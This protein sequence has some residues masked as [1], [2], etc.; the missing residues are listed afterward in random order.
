MIKGKA[1]TY[2]SGCDMIKAQSVGQ[3]A[4]DYLIRK[5]CEICLHEPVLELKI[6]EEC[7]NDKA[8]VVQNWS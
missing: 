2:P 5:K 6:V 8:G 4:P 7:G 1:G 3:P